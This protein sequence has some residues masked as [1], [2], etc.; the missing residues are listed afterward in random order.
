MSKGKII[1]ACSTL[2]LLVGLGLAIGGSKQPG[3]TVAATANPTLSV[4]VISPE[5]RQIPIDLTAN[6]SIAA[7][8]EAVIGAEVGDLRLNTVNVQI[9]EAV[10]KGQILATFS[11][12]SVLTDV[13][14]SRA[15]LAEAEANLA[16]AK[17]NAARASKISPVGALSAQQVDQYLTAEKTAA[18]KVQLAKAQLDAQLLRLK[19]TKVL[20]SDDGVISSRTA[21]L[22][23]VATKGQ[24][25]FR[26]IR[27]N[28]LEWRGEVTAAEMTQLTPGV[29]VTVEV[30]NVGSI[31]G[32]LRFLAP[33]LD[34]QSR[35]GLV[36][37]DLPHAARSGLRAGMFARGEFHL[38]SSSGL[39]VP[40]DA[41]SLREGFSYVFRLAEQSGDRARVNQVKVQL[42]RRSG[43]KLEVLSGL[44]PEDRLV[45]G[46]ASFLADGDNVRVVAP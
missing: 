24:E 12:E 30:P 23:A 21:T 18:A 1:A 11:D 43:A 36:Y 45:A 2:L 46:G 22:G 39:T 33:T 35:N 5:I 16:E 14:Q 7:W 27:Q 41:L 42:G 17:V 32:T 6:G 31:E 37:V 9:G 29:A 10:K 15:M 8:Q 13:A 40:Q 38:G 34:E 26:L 25:L 3:P 28:R 4:S 44:N 20:A 19:Y